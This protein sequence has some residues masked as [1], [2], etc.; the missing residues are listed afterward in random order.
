VADLQ[1]EFD[2]V[3]MV[4]DGINDLCAMKKANLSILTEEQ[5]GDKPVELYQAAHHV[6]KDVREVVEIVK[7]LSKA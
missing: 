1:G 6:V 2:T 3:V 4:G 5:P 7:A